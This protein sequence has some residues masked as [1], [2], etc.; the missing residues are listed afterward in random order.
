MQAAYLTHEHQTE[1]KDRKSDKTFEISY[2]HHCLVIYLA[3]APRCPSLGD[4]WDFFKHLAEV[5]LCIRVDTLIILNDQM[6]TLP[7][8]VSK[9]A[10]KCISV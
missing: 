9:T 6:V 4:L 1:P 7:G 2:A 8:I 5:D 3:T 10:I